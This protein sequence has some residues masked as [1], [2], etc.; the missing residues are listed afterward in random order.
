MPTGR[1][2][3]AVTNVPVSMGNA[4]ESQAKAAARMRFQPCSIFTTIISTAMVSSAASRPSAMMREPSVTRSGSN[5]ATFMTTN[6]TASTSGTD[7]ATTRPERHPRDMKLTTSTIV[8]AS[9][10]ERRNSPT[11]FLDDARLVCDLVDLAR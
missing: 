5:P 1:K 10:N 2:P 9:T 6:T 11:D 7:V 3:D 4:V 8:S